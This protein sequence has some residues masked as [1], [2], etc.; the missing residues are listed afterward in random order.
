MEQPI[1]PKDESADQE[2][3]R[4][5]AARLAAIAPAGDPPM[6][7]IHEEAP[8]ADDSMPLILDGERTAAPTE[9]VTL[10]LGDICKRIGLRITTE[11]ITDVLQVPLR[12]TGG[13][14]HRFSNS[15]F[16][17]IIV[18]FILHLKKLV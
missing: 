14:T 16:D 10:T 17:R 3:V 5:E 4:T 12:A 1:K 15:D 7:P 13:R 9:A 18:G 6:E 8:Q 2:A 11:F